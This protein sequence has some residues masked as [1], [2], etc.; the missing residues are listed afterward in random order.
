MIE[1]RAVDG[2]K[3]ILEHTKLSLDGSAVNAAD[4]HIAA[5]QSA[6]WGPRLFGGIRPLLWVLMISA[7]LALLVLGRFERVHVPSTRLTTREKL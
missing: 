3:S 4:T 5:H 6:G 7:L 2:L 1:N